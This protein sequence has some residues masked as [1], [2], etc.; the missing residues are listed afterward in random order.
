MALQMTGEAIAIM[1]N[2]REDVNVV[3]QPILHVNG[4]WD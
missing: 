2:I 1:M 4:K 3:R